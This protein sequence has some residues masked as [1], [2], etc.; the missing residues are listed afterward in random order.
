MEHIVYFSVT[1]LVVY[2]IYYFASIRKAKKNKKKI[3]IE[4]QYL[5]LSYG[6]DINKIQYRNFLNT[7]AIVGS[8][9]VAL[10]A[11]IVS[12]FK[13]VIWQLLF[14]FVF[15]V[16]VIIISFMLIGKYYQKVQNNIIVNE[17]KK[18]VKKKERKK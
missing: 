9:D 12:L 18:K 2:M 3:P 7:I 17:D 5:I 15:V 4:V 1:F 13:E 6:I 16:P 10:V 8:F 14:G 11:T